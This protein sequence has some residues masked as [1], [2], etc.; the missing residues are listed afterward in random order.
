[1]S[2]LNSLFCEINFLELPK[3]SWNL[4]MLSIIEKLKN[5]L[6]KSLKNWYA[7]W[8][9]KLKNWH[10]FWHAGTPSWKFGTPL[11]GW[12]AK[13]ND[14]KAF[15]TLVGKNK[16]LPGFWHVD[17]TGTHVTRFSKLPFK[18]TCFMQR[19]LYYSRCTALH[20]QLL[21]VL[22]LTDRW[23]TFYKT[24]VNCLIG[25]HLLSSAINKKGGRG[26]YPE[27][28][29]GRCSTQYMIRVW[30]LQYEFA[31]ARIDWFTW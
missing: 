31:D 25:Q 17:H 4:Q 8:Q 15:G 12:D 7:F 5:S 14:W 23:A 19:I 2:N 24:R 11:A 29:G 20:F 26:R 16:K 18:N 1:M 22:R 9:A 6:E 28:P 10:A 3:Y 13:L 27:V 30:K 21:Q